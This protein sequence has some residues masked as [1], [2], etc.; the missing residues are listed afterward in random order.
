MDDLVFIRRKVKRMRQEALDAFSTIAS[1]GGVNKS[2]YREAELCD[3]IVKEIDDRIKW[4]EKQNR[5]LAQ[6]R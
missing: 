4:R 2:L 6:G 1:L 5:R 3:D